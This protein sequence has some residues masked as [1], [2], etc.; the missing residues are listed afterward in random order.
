MSNTFKTLCDH[1]LSFQS[2]CSLTGYSYSKL[3]LADKES[4]Q[5]FDVR[6]ACEM[7]KLM[8][9]KLDTL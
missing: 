3:L 8:I 6:I 7:I 2:L 1:F 9:F 4:E 5:E